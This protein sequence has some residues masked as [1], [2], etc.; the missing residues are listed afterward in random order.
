[1]STIQTIKPIDPKTLTQEQI[2]EIMSRPMRPFEKKKAVKLT[3]DPLRLKQIEDNPI[4]VEP[5]EKVIVL[6]PNFVIDAKGFI[7]LD[8]CPRRMNKDAIKAYNDYYKKIG[9][10]YRISD[11]WAKWYKPTQKF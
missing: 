10:N 7:N 11:S 5:S 8:Y 6:K 2:N 3:M 1:M 9:V 4:Q